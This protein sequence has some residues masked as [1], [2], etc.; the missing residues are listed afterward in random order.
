MTTCSRNRKKERPDRQKKFAN[1]PNL[2]LVERQ[3]SYNIIE[4]IQVHIQDG[5]S[6]EAPENRSTVIRYTVGST[7]L[8]T[9]TRRNF[10]IESVDSISRDG[11]DAPIYTIHYKTPQKIRLDTF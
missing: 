2:T 7:T 11:T 4:K 6:E 10:I 9:P 1:E 8:S 3:T 5:C